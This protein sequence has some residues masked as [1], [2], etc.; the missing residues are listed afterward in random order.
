[1]K[2][3]QIMKRGG[4]KLLSSVYYLCHSYTEGNEYFQINME[5]EDSRA[6][7]LRLSPEEAAHI[8]LATGAYLERRK[9]LAL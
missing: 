1:M 4:F 2:L 9:Q 5:V 8:H 3:Y 6:Y 7:A